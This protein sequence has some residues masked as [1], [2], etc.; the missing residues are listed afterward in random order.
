[1][2]APSRGK[3]LG[4]AACT[5]IVVGNMVGSGFYLSPA[6][7]APYGNLAIVIWIV[8]GAGAICLGLTFARLAK[9]SPAVGGPY[10]YTRLAY[11][12]FP[13]FLIAWGYWISIWASLPVIAVAFAGVVIDFFPFLRGRG[14][15][16]LLTLSVIWLVVL[17]NLRG[18]HAAGLFSEITTYAKMI[19]FGAVALLGLFYIDFSHFADFNPSGQPLLQASAALAPLTMFAYLGL[20]SATVPAGD[21]RDA[22]RTIPRSTVLGIAIAVTL[23]VLGTIVVMGLVPREELV[24]SVAPFSEAARRMW[25]PA[26]ELAI[27]LA[28]VLSSIGALNGWTLLMGQVPMAAA[29]DGL[30]PPLFSRL[31]VRN[32]PAT[33]IVVSATLATILVLVQA[34]GSEGFSSIYRLFVG[35]STMTAVIPYAFCALASSLVSARVSGGTVIPRVTLIE[36]VGFT[37]AIFTLYGCGAEPVLYGLVLLLLSIPVYI[38][39]RRR[40]FVPGDFGQ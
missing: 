37:F 25:G 30:F 40:S 35:L 5:A 1:M 21:V 26:G 18:V 23:Y 3:S 11:G 28:V 14:T 31:S 32:V 2:S 9:L 15:A 4:L 17:V 33:G 7:V 39:Q 22:E 12:D 34:A 24:H 6:A 10:A 20:E 29:R 27:S 19:P 8:M 36:L 38:W 16:T 13:G